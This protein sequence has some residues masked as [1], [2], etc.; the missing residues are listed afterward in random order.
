MKEKGDEI[1]LK[2]AS[3][4]QMV[5]RQIKGWIT[6]SWGRWKDRFL[7]KLQW[8]WKVLLYRG[9]APLS[10]HSLLSRARI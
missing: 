10:E 2:R 9:D 5:L 8:L 3:T 4:P 7:Q 6:G 1:R